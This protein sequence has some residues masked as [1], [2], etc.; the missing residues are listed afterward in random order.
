MPARSGTSPEAEILTIEARRADALVIGDAQYLDRITHDAYFH[1]D[2]LGK[3]RDKQAFLQSV[4]NGEAQSR[5]YTTS[6]V[7]LRII[8]DTAF[9]SGLFENEFIRPG[10]DV[11]R[12][13]GRFS[14]V[15]V[16]CEGTWLNL[17]H[18]GT[19]I[20]EPRN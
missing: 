5:Q 11:L 1:I 13:L 3:L 9:V 18:Q 10:G 2:G 17:L 7:E 14:R 20:D 8:Q 19:P 6:D 4:R 15:Y 12:R 16:R